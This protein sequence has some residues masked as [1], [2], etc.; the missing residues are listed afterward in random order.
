MTSF[1]LEPARKTPVWGSYD[2]VVAGGGVAGIAA[3]LAAARNGAKTALVERQFLLGGLATAGLVTIYLPL[4]DG[5]GNQVS[6]GIAEELLR[7]SIRYGAEAEYPAAWLDG[8]D[9]KARR[10]KRFR[11]RFNASVFAIAAEQLLLQS[12]VTLLYGTSICGVSADAAGE[13]VNALLVENKTGRGALEAGMFID[14]TGDADVLAQAGERT[15]VFAQ[16]NVLAAWYYA[17]EDG[18][19]C[20][21]ALGACDVPDKYKKDQAQ[22]DENIGT[23]RFDGLDGMQLSR[24]TVQSHQRTLE[25]FLKKGGIAD[26]HALTAIASIPQV[27]MSRRLDGAYTLDDDAMHVH[28]ADSVGTFSDWRKAGPAYELPL[29]TLH[30]TRMK[31]LLAAGRCI[32]VTDAMW[33]ITRVIPVCAVSGE[34]AGTAAALTQD[35]THADVAKIQKRLCEN[36]AQVHLPDRDSDGLGA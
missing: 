36:G 31:N 6:F 16:G 3:A 11:V 12:G 1:Y 26:T 4:C 34:A 5:M 18:A 30:G 9:S 24:V 13:R 14:A 10:E 2:V 32:S 21:H 22:V 27:R 8:G 29:G 19:L 23:F 17:L 28:F 15:A 25:D 35:M 7:L 33:D 20:L